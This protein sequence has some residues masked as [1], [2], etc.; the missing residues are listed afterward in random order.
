MWYERKSAVQ[1]LGR[2]AD[3]KLIFP[4]MIIL[5]VLIVIVMAPTLMQM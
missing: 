2:V 3:T 1:K 4:L 5:S